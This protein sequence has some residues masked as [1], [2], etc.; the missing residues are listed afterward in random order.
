MGSADC[1]GLEYCGIY[2]K[3]TITDGRISFKLYLPHLK[4][5]LVTVQGADHLHWT[6]RSIY[7]DYNKQSSMPLNRVT[8][9]ELA[10]LIPELEYFLR[11]EEQTQGWGTVLCV[12]MVCSFC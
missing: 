3:W 5:A 10:V 4:C 11:M 6:G 7:N 2:F 8:D 9:R 12:C 1:V